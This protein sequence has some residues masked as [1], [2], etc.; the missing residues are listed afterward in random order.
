MRRLANEIIWL[1]EVG[2]GE[3]QLNPNVGV[4]AC[5]DVEVH[6]R[7]PQSTSH[8]QVSTNDD[9]L[10][11][12]IRLKRGVNVAPNMNVGLIVSSVVYPSRIFVPFRLSVHRPGYWHVDAERMSSCP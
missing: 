1:G 8:W 6:V 4:S 7:S 9:A 2:W 5:G 11:K 10:S 12:N 3:V